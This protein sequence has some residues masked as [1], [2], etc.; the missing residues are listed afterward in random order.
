MIRFNLKAYSCQSF[1]LS[2]ARRHRIAAVLVILCA[3]ASALKAQENQLLTVVEGTFEVNWLEVGCDEAP[4]GMYAPVDGFW[5]D[6]IPWNVFE[7]KLPSH[8]LGIQDLVTEEVWTIAD[9]S[10]LTRRQCELLKLRASNHSVNWDFL[11]QSQHKVGQV[12]TPLLRF[13]INRNHYERLESIDFALGKSESF[14]LGVIETTNQ[15]SRN[16]PETSPLNSG[17]FIRI[18]IPADGIYRINRDWIQAAGFDPDSLDP[19]LLKLF[20]NGGDMLPFDNAVVRPLG[21]MPAAIAFEGEEDGIWDA[22]DALY[23]WGDGPDN[24]VPEG[25]I[26]GWEHER[27]SFNDAACYFLQLDGGV[28]GEM[29]RVD[30]QQLPIIESDTLI[31]EYW[32]KQFHEMEL[33]S[34]NRSGREWFGESFG[35]VPS[36]TVTFNVPHAT[37][38]LGALA[39]KFAAQSMGASSVFEVTAGDVSGSASPSY[40]SQTSTS[41]VAN[42]ASGAAVGVLKVGSG[43]NARVEVNVN[44]NAG[45]TG[46]RG[47]LDYVR[48]AQECQLIMPGPQ[49]NFYAASS[50]SNSVAEYRVS[51]SPQ[52]KAVWDITIGNQPEA[53]VL[54]ELED[55]TAWRAQMDTN[56]RFVAFSEYGFLEPVYQGPVANVDLHQFERADLVIVTREDYIAAA[57]RLAN[58]HADEGLEVLVTTQRAVF[59]DF[60]SGN[61]DPTALKMLMMML[62]DRALEGGWDAP[63]YLQIM[64]DGT[65]ANRS[66]LMASPFVITYQSENSISPTSSYVSDDYFGFLADEYG[67]GIGDKMAIGVGRIACATADQANAMVDKVEAYMEHP[68]S[69]AVASGCADESGGDDGR[70]RNR[71]CFVSDD[72]DGNGGPTEIEHMQNSDEHAEKLAENHPEYDVV[73]IYL[74]AYPQ[75]STP[76][77]ERY[78]QAQEAIDR[79]VREGALIMNYIGHGGEKGWSHERVLNTTTIQNWENLKRMPLFMTATCELARYD[80]PDVESAGEMMVM[81]PDGGA[82]AMLTTTRVVFSGSNQQLNRAFYDVAL[83]DTTSQALRLGDIVKETKNDPQVSNSSNKRNFTLLGDV[84]LKLNY[85]EHEVRFTAVPDTL[86]ALGQATVSGFIADGNSAVLEDFEGI[87]HVKVFDKPSQITSL[88]NDG[89]PNPHAFEVRRNVLFS[90]VATVESGQFDFDFVVPRDIDYSYGPGRISAYAVSDSSDAH[91]AISDFII[92]GVSEV[93]EVDNDPPVVDLFLNDTLFQDG[94]LS[95]ANPLLLAR[96]FDEGGINSSGVGIGHDIRVILDGES[97]QSVVLNDFYTSDLDTYKGGTVRYPFSALTDGMHTLSLA[98]W[99]VHNNKGSASIDFFVASDFETVLGEVFAF[100]NPS[101]A[102]F[103]FSIEHNQTCQEG[104]MNLEVFSSLG[105][106]VHSAGYPWHVAGFQNEILQWDARNQATGTR[107]KAGVYVFRLTLQSESGSVAQYADQIVVLRP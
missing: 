14:G 104:K 45:A 71:I 41:N 96:L 9:S 1:F 28:A 52:L 91:G 66:N 17:Q 46:A 101:F 22:N 82:I 2:T 38:K 73:K 69:T 40:T 21:L 65:F 106:L 32:S 70:W 36:R 11:S 55:E 18:A 49:L 87:I 85:P 81:N 20:G 76:G 44:F 57:E 84:A 89:A 88:N 62:R 98:A 47:W 93:F 94:G 64:G 86:N 4:V 77:G 80:D 56:R 99:D 97:S 8:W 59:D 92:G 27:N 58:L 37:E 34:I 83:F 48:I 68:S 102:G 78:P 24:W 100:P 53:L 63:R 30:E 105:K 43:L 103:K 3:C 23:F 75:E 39:Y 79:Q 12:Q 16:W 67:E 61:V 25:A 29:H 31:T 35:S 74:D 107:V 10:L 51:Q 13:N 5:L 33:E 42:L 7:K 90:G 50:V 54:E 19:R 15:R 72:M 95:D 26:R 6:E 60:S